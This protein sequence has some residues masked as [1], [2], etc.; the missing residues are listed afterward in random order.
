MF[1]PAMSAE[2]LVDAEPDRIWGT[3][4]YD[5]RVARSRMGLRGVES[6]DSFAG[7]SASEIGV[8]VSPTT[9]AAATSSTWSKYLPWGAAAVGVYLLY[10]WSRDG[11][12]E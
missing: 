10:R 8:R 6:V 12:E 1:I 5:A 2:S 9:T 4:A 11:D 7:P 3:G